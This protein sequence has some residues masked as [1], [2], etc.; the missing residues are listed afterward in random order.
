MSDAQGREA[1]IRE[2]RAALLSLYN[3][4]RLRKSVLV[5]LLG[6]DGRANP[7]SALRQILTEAI[8]ALKPGAEVPLQS[9]AWRVYHVLTYRY[10]EQSDLRTV[11]ANLGI[12]ERQLRRHERE[13]EQMLADY[14]WSHY[15]LEA[16]AQALEASDSV[17][18]QPRRG[19]QAG[20]LN[21][22][23]PGREQELEWM[24][25][26]FPS[27]T[28]GLE[29]VV[30]TVLKTLSPLM[31]SSGVQV[32]CRLPADLPPVS[33]QLTT[34]RQALSNL[35]VAAVRSVPGGRVEVAA[36]SDRR[37]VGLDVRAERIQD[38]SSAPGGSVAEEVEMAR[39]L[40][41]LF[42]G[43]LEAHPAQEG[44]QPFAAR[45]VLPVAEPIPVLV[46]DDNADTLRLLQRYLTGT[47]YRFI[48]A[49]DAEQALALVEE[50]APRAIML[51]VMLPNM[52]DWE[53]LGRLREH[54]KL[55]GVPI[56]VCTI[57]PQEELALALGAADFLRKP[58]SRQELLAALD[59][60]VGLN[61]RGS[62]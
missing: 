34:L 61:A 39:Q 60:Q 29:S 53:L 45:L 3:P 46:I 36:E 16:R 58:V 15:G 52:A 41:A 11:A 1:F 26:S 28:A 51:D 30:T 7:S 31:Q 40:I 44:T 55:R 43:D 23:T 9:P 59:R 4:A 48:G 6:L 20:A 12:S 27:E 10:V 13:A 47:R 17:G 2:L 50:S 62:P 32:E 14:L 57:L 22:K 5:P 25:E 33:G 35:L 49:R 21:A 38:T 19:E 18:G 42:G 56:I 37:G 54:P 8:Q 24:R